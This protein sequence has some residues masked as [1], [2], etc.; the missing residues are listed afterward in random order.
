MRVPS[1]PATGIATITVTVT[2]NKRSGFS[3]E[4]TLRQLREEIFIAR[5]YWWTSG[6]CTPE[7]PFVRSLEIDTSTSVVFGPGQATGT[8]WYLSASAGWRDWLRAEAT[9]GT[10]SLV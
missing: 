10:I 7:T 8:N 4:G 2:C 1:T 5:G 9:T 6:D 3:A